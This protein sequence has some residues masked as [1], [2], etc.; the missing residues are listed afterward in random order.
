MANSMN[1]LRNTLLELGIRATRILNLGFHPPSNTSRG[2]SHLPNYPY[3]DSDEAGYIDSFSDSELGPVILVLLL[4]LFLFWRRKEICKGVLK[5][6]SW[7]LNQ[8][9]VIL[10]LL[11]VLVLCILG[12]S[13][14]LYALIIWILGIYRDT[15]D[16]EEEEEAGAQEEHGGIHENG[17]TQ[18]EPAATQ[19]QQSR[20]QEEQPGPQK[21]REAAAQKEQPGTQQEEDVEKAGAQEKEGARPQEEGE[22]SGAAG[23]EASPGN[24]G[25]PQTTPAEATHPYPNTILNTLQRKIVDQYHQLRAIQAIIIEDCSRKESLETNE[26][27]IQWF[28][29]PLEQQPLATVIQEWATARRHHELMRTRASE[30]ERENQALRADFQQLKRRKFKVKDI[31][32][33]RDTTANNPD[34]DLFKAFDEV[35]QRVKYVADKLLKAAPSPEAF[36]QNPFFGHLLDQHSLTRD[37]LVHHRVDKRWTRSLISSIIWSFFMENLFNTPFQVFGDRTKAYHDDW[38]P[39]TDVSDASEMWRWLTVHQILQ[40]GTVE[41]PGLKGVKLTKDIMAS[42]RQQRGVLTMSLDNVLKKLYPNTGVVPLGP[43]VVGSLVRLAIALALMMTKQRACLRLVAPSIGEFYSRT[44]SRGIQCL[45]K[46]ERDS[47]DII[48]IERPALAAWGNG[49]GES[50]DQCRFV[51]KAIVIVVEENLHNRDVWAKLKKQLLVKLAQTEPSVAGISAA[52]QTETQ[53]GIWDPSK[54]NHF[55]NQEYTVPNTVFIPRTGEQSTSHL[56]PKKVRFAELPLFSP[57]QPPQNT[58]TTQPIPTTFSPSQPQPVTQTWNPSHPIVF[59]NQSSTTAAQP[60]PQPTAPVETPQP[61][62]VSNY[63]FPSVEEVAAAEEI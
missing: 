45:E 39:G 60:A 10:Q 5:G 56:Q 22:V 21:Q 14:R 50:M 13:E 62:Q 42:I 63:R 27:I 57:E 35:H 24:T 17:D 1:F 29:L 26:G 11:F 47:G 2:H 12:L 36:V 33:I 9:L 3:Y 4:Y 25:E 37:V 61:V 46:Y 19:E 32:E 55:S 43:D 58:T 54:G 41:Y 8:T 30:L 48:V 40:K 20:T 7:L 38:V 53:P 52:T 16:E 34:S 31:V 59:A 23:P 49:L 28:D 18:G 44:H 6:I 15:Q 51:G